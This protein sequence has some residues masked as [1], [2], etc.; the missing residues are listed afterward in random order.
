MKSKRF[1]AFEAILLIVFALVLAGC[2]GAKPSSTGANDEGQDRVAGHSSEVFELN[3]GNWAPSTHHYVYNV[4]EPWKKHVEEKTNGRIKVN[5]Y[6]GAT[7][8]AAKSVWEDVKGGVYDVGLVPV[9]YYYDSDLFP[10]TI[11]NLPFAFPDS[12]SAVKVVSKMGEKYAKDAFNDVVLMGLVFSDPYDLF[13][14][15]P[16]RKAEDVKKAKFRTQGKSESELIKSLGATP[17]SVSVTETYEALQKKT[18]DMTFYSPIGGVGNKFYEVAPY[19]TKIGVSVT[20][21]IAVMNK[22]FYDKLPDDLKRMFDEDFNKKLVDLYNESY[23]KEREQSYRELEK[24]VEGKGEVITLTPEELKEFK[25]HAKAQWDR[26]VEDA[27]KKG[28]EGEE[29]MNDFKKL[30]Q[31]EGL[32]LP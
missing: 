7:L 3:V 28:Y 30:L 13:S 16:I 15:K 1:L 32:E 20:P 8:G 5:L 19:I 21:L 6:H 23:V 22:G 24:L 17:V 29:M 27:N 4:L 25:R 2:G 26:W 11:G 31:E 9:S 18:L 10:Y 14:T 12:I